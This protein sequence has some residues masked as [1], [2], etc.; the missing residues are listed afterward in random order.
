MMEETP[1][2]ARARR[3]RALLWVV[4]LLVLLVVGLIAATLAIGGVALRGLTGAALVQ[5]VLAA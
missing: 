1:D 2:E 3:R 5:L 4:P